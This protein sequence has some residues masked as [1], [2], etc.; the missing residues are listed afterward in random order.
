MNWSYSLWREHK[1]ENTETHQLMVAQSLCDIEPLFLLSLFQQE[2]PFILRWRK[3]LVGVSKCSCPECKYV[4]SVE[5]VS[6]EHN[7]NLL[8]LCRNN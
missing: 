4:Y 8:L 5:I 2:E 7:S 6:Q 1:A 3:G